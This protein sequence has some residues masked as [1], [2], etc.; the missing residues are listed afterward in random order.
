MNIHVEALV[1][2]LGHNTVIFIHTISKLM[3]LPVNLI[4]LM[5]MET[6]KSENNLRNRTIE[7]LKL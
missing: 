1:H 2:R 6:L 4:V 7:P 3:T 5:A